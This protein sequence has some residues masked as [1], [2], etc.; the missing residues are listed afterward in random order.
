VVGVP[1]DN[2]GSSGIDG[3]IADTPATSF[4]IPSAGLYYVELSSTNNGAFATYGYSS[5]GSSGT[6]MIALGAP[7]GLVVNADSPPPPPPNVLTCKGTTTLQ[8]SSTANNCATGVAVRAVDLYTTTNGQVATTVS[9]AV[10]TVLAG[11]ATQLF[12]ITLGAESCTT[13]VN[14]LACPEAI[15][16]RIACNTKTYTLGAGKCGS[17]LVPEADLYVLSA[18]VGAPAGSRAT[19][20]AITS[21]PVG[22]SLGPGVHRID[23]VATNGGATCTAVVTV[24]PCRPVVVSTTTAVKI[25]NQPN[26][27]A[28]LLAPSAVVSAATLGQG[29]LSINARTSATGSIIP[30]PLK[31]GK[32]YVQVVYPGG[33]K[34]AISA[35]SVPV[36]I[37][38]VDPPLAAIKSSIVRDSTGFICARGTSSTAT[39]ACLSTS[40]STTGVITLKDNCAVSLLTRKY[41][42]SGTYC[43]TTL[44]TSTATKVC[45]PVVRGGARR[46]VVYTMT[47]TDK[48]GKQGQVQ[49]PIAA[50]HYSN[51]PAGVTCYYA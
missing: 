14:V 1:F 23:V 24:N 15:P 22:G 28:A 16:D 50:Y 9:P 20:T 49:I 44:P 43:P 5:Y 48:G 4:N 40:T 18:G 10:G 34:S 45:V 27:C 33:L 51:K 6:Y 41:A 13:T 32:Y 37:Q 21:L 29:A 8:L 38:D 30:Q 11:G 47:V 2:V 25:V 36:V 42:C 3:N 7:S 35:G 39:R 31:A 46:E 12:T 26:T 19:G 17:T